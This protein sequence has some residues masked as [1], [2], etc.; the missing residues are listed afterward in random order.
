MAE[1]LSVNSIAQLLAGDGLTSISK[2]V[3]SGPNK[4]AKVLSAGIP[5]LLA[6]MKRNASTLEGEASLG[7]ALGDHSGVDTG[8]VVGFLKNVDTKDGKKILGHVLGD[9]QPDTV[10]KISRA[11]GLSGS[12]VI[13]I[14]AMVAP[15]LLSLLGNQQS[16]NTQPAQQTASPLQLL[17]G[18]QQQTQQQSSGGLG[19][20][21]LLGSVLGGGSSQSST[22][23]L[24]SSAL[25]ILTGGGA[26]EPEPQ[27]QESDS[28]GLLSGFLNLFR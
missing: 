4:V 10:E 23:G 12:T 11:S 28:G 5:V 9:S 8:D 1:K 16:Q 18:A 21:N 2:K 22:G 14:L 24:A 26:S 27:Q 7:K 6:N 15:L 20:F 17:S 13:K 3:R 19:I 25:S